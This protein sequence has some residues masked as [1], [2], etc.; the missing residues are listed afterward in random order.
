MFVL[1]RL[2][3]N[4]TRF[5]IKTKNKAKIEKRNCPNELS[6]FTFDRVVSFEDKIIKKRNKNKIEKKNKSD[7]FVQN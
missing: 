1:D 5:D 7:N 6:D 2:K 3:K 4:R